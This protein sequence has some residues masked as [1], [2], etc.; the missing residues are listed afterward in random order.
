MA[1]PESGYIE[2]PGHFGRS[3]PIEVVRFKQAAPVELPLTV[4]AHG[5]FP[6]EIPAG[7]VQ[8]AFC[9]PGR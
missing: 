2:K 7:K 5:T 3:G 9:G 6:A 1:V 8:K 4:Q